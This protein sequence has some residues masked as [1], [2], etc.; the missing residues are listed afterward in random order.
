M[1]DHTFS[2]SNAAHE[3]SGNHNDIGLNFGFD[4]S[5]RINDKGIPS[6]NLALEGATDA[7]DAF[8]RQFAFKLSTVVEKSG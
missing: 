5:A 7:Y 4:N 3:S 8:E 1:H 6:K 2:C